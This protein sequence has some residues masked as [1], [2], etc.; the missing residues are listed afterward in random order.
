MPAPSFS[1]LD[2]MNLGP[3]THVGDW[4][5]LARVGWGGYGAVYLVRHVH[6]PRR[7]GALKLPLK[8]GPLSRRLEREAEMLARVKHPHV[9]C[10]L[11]AGHW[12]MPGATVRLPFVVMEYVPGMQLYAHVSQR[13][14]R[15]REALALFEQ[16]ALALHALH[17]V[18]AVHRDVKGPNLLV[19]EG[20]RHLMLVDLGVGD[21]AGA[22]RLTGTSLP[23]GS[24]DY[25]S[26][27]ALRFQ[28]EHLEDSE[29]HY[30]FQ[31]ADDLYALGVTWYRALTGDYPVHPEREWHLARLEGRALDSPCSLNPCLPPEVGALVLRL[32]APRAEARPASAREVAEALA[33]LRRGGGDALE[34]LLFE[35]NAV[36]PTPRSLATELPPRPFAHEPTSPSRWGALVAGVVLAIVL[37]AGLFNLAHPTQE[38]P[39]MSES[40]VSTPASPTS[41]ARLSPLE[42]DFMK[43]LAAA[44][45]LV[46]SGCAGLP[47]QPA[48]PQDCPPETLAAMARRGLKP[49]DGDY[50]Q[51]DIHDQGELSEHADRGAGP[52]V[53]AIGSEFDAN[54]WFPV[55]TKLYGFTWTGG[56]MVQAYWTEAELPDGQKLPVCMVLGF[57]ERGG[58][59]KYPGAQPGTFSLSKRAPI[60]VTRRFERPE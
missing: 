23:P 11:D 47:A 32:L 57:D 40:K 28:R 38:D 41:A 27:E 50:V 46:S 29:A 8:L 52:I 34:A 24:P 30:E 43:S 49:G 19:R 17:E 51:F 58:Y 4:C 13:Q 3:G 56:E 26:P 22:F 31:R 21:Y 59:R 1:P 5:V 54:S 39:S 36:A 53:S 42:L 14:V 18:D 10:L 48:W 15:V 2:P 33:T 9:V 44:V 55:G 25:R 45:C 20:D 16:S 37:A 12:E 35:W 6:E 60:T 7:Q